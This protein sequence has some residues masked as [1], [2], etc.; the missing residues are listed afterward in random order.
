MQR[1]QLHNDDGNVKQITVQFPINH[2]TITCK[3]CN[4]TMMM[5]MLNKSLLNSI[6]HMTIT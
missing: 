6:N 1:M 3:E 2:M 5:G 4:Y